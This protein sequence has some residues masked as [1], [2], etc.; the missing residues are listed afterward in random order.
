[1]TYLLD[2]SAFLSLVERSDQSIREIV[3]SVEAP[4]PRSMGVMGELIHGREVDPTNPERRSTVE[5]Y[6]EL[7]EWARGHP[8]AF[9][10]ARCGEIS[11]VASKEGLKIGQNDRWIIAEAADLGATLITFDQVQAQLARR[12]ISRGRSPYGVRLLGG[13][14]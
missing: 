7:T 2:T 1:M 10:A 5:M 13:E 9:L 11:A 6:L 14:G 3:R 4:L 8:S 12:C